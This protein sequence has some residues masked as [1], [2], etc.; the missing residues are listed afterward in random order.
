MPD[1]LKNQKCPVC[2]EDKLTLREDEMDIP[3]FGN[4]FIFTMI[5]EGCSYKKSDIEAAEE[6]PACKYTFELE[7][8]DDLNVRVVKSGEATVRIPRIMD[9]ESGPA[10]DGYI[11]NVEG[12]LERVKAAL[13]STL[14]AEEEEDNQNKLRSLI[15]KVSRAMVGREKLKIII[16]DPTG[17]SAIISEKAVK[18]KL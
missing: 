14:D 8:D 11:T 17:N 1:E 6:K 12:L 3:H 5:C 13:Q 10:S 7:N 18:A 15:K 9:I 2:N 4:T 16:E